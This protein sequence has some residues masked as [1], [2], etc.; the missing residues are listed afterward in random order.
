M[1]GVCSLS[2]FPRGWE[3]LG[4]LGWAIV[5]ER[6]G[7]LRFDENGWERFGKLA[8]AYQSFID[9]QRQSLFD[10]HSPI[11]TVLNFNNVK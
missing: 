2:G 9:T 8:K 3:K 6:L 4:K 5:L 1:P 10:I 7:E 11:H